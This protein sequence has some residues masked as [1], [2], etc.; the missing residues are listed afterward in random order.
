MEFLNTFVFAKLFFF[1]GIGIIVSWFSVLVGERGA[2]FLFGK[3]SDFLCFFVCA[4]YWE[5]C[6]VFDKSKVKLDL[7][8]QKNLHVRGLRWSLPVPAPTL[9]TW[10][11]RCSVADTT[12]R[13][14]KCTA[15]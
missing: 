6:P 3:S 4:Y 7:P 1:A 8:F 5:K 11:G 2:C 14:R 15:C 13:A 9:H 12:A 10:K